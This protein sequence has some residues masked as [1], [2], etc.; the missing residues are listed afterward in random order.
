MI[1]ESKLLELDG[2]AGDIVVGLNEY[3][4]QF[5]ECNEPVLTIPRSDA[6]KLKDW[7]NKYCI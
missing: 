7:L 3:G 4:L 6:I 2:F 1:K 5:R